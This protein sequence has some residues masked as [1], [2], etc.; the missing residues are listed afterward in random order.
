[1][2]WWWFYLRQQ[3]LSSKRGSPSWRGSHR[4]GC[5][6]FLAPDLVQRIVRG[7]QPLDLTADRPMDMIPLHEALDAQ[8]MLLG[9]SG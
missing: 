5:L 2:N 4:A 3:P 6:A 7:D 9:M 1:M 8:R